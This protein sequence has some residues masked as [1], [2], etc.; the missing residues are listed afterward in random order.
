MVSGSRINIRITVLSLL[1]FSGVT[2]SIFSQGTTIGGIVNEYIHVVSINGPDNV[3]VTDASAFAAGDTVLLIQMKGAIINITESGSY[4]G[5]RESTGKPGAYE[6]MIVQ[7]VNTGTG[8]VVFTSNML[9]TYDVAGMVQLIKVPYY[10]SANVSST[11][12]CSPWDSTAKRGGVVSFIV[13]STL[14][15]NADI[16]VSGKGFTGGTPFTGNGICTVTDQLTYD[17]FG[18]PDS[19]M[20]S[21]YKGEGLSI[22][23]YVGPGDEPSVFP[24]FAKGKGANFT[25]GGG[26]NGRFAGGGGGAGYGAGGTGGVEINTC[27]AGNQFGNGIGGRQV[28]FTDLEGGILIGSGGGSSTYF[29]GATATAGGKGGGIIIIVCDTPPGSSSGNAGAGG[30]GGGGSVALYTQSFSENIAVS[31]LTMSAKGGNG[32]N[33]NNQFGEGGGGGGG[34][35]FTNNPAFPPNVVRY[36]TQGPVGTRTGGSLGGTS[37]QVGI[38]STTFVPVLNGFLF[39]SVRSSVSY[40]KEDSVCSNMRPPKIIGTRPVGGSGS[41][42]YVWQKSYEPT[43]ASPIILTNDAD[44]TNYTPTLA[45]AVTP[46][47]T[48]WFRRIIADAGPPSITDISKAVKITV[49]PA[50]SNNMVGSPDTICFNGNPPLI[51]QI[52]PDL[53]VPTTKYLFYQWQD[54]SSSGTWGPVRGSN[55]DYDPPEGLQ[56]TTWYRRKVI[57]GSCADSSARVKM[58]VLPLITNNLILNSPPDICYGMSFDNL[59]GSTPLTAPALGGGDN[60]YRFTWISNINGAGWTNAPGINDQSGYNPAEQGERIP[61]N[62]YDIRRIVY[63]GSNNVCFDTSAVV[64]LRDFPAITNNYLDMSSVQTIC[65]G[66]A[67]AKITGSV[68]SNG[69]EIFTYTW[70]DSTNSTTQWQDIPG[71]TG[72]TGSEFQPPVLV[73]TT[74]YRRIALSSACSDIS[75]SIRITVDPPVTNNNV[76]LSV[77]GGSADTTICN[78][79]THAGL[80]GTAV[81]GASYQWLAAAGQGVLV[82]IPGATQQDYQDPAALTATTIYRRQVSRGVCVDTSNAEVTVT[83]LPLISNNIITTDQSAVCENVLPDQITGGALSGGSGSFAY[84][85]QQSTDGGSNW[86]MAD[87]TNTLGN[88]QPPE[89]SG[90]IMYRRMVTSGPAGCCSSVSAPLALTINPAPAS[91]VF[92]GE[93]ISVYSFDRSYIL[94]ADPPSIPGETGFWTVLEPGTASVDNVS[95]SKSKVRNL[96]RGKNL[97]VWSVTNGLCEISDSVSI[98]L[99]KDFIPQ[100][101]SPNGDAWNNRFVIEGLD[102]SEEIAELTILNGAGT[103]VYYTSNRD[104]MDRLGW[105]EQQ[106]SRAAGG[107]LLLSPEGY[108]R[109]QPG[110]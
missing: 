20:N 64:H 4:G 23:G 21:G 83:V 52:M 28:R 86:E 45:D 73:V 15:L 93:D 75:N 34:Y 53:V 12:S 11:I 50:I 68:P 82:P 101:F 69:N 95:D 109:E 39:N 59:N 36:V 85:W 54:S 48:V 37:G 31:A 3:T 99:L 66:L 102:L 49:H 41:Y 24:S 56:S 110:N 14:T 88:Y 71:Y 51:Q 81:S 58:T 35:I 46:T 57:S 27:G 29:T 107:H 1:F 19:Y 30:G 90:D 32:G 8:L 87:G 91:A 89:L 100:G 105:Q 6:F 96:S 106:G 17:K 84:F 78:G 98:D 2:Y 62:E 80:T 92:A 42:T 65:S 70:Q 103:S 47:D 38:L 5:Y 97:F 94:N 22:R 79:Q 16:D 43:F 7:S 55:K 25:S 67:P 40:N 76:F 26:A 61:S 77:P 9:N 104:G 74:S 63:S 33:A 44:P 13:G 72:V 10:N 18:Y 108:N 60:S